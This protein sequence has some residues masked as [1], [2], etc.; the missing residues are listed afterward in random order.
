M[1]KLFFTILAYFLLATAF[2]QTKVYLVPTLHGMHKTNTQY[3]YDS[4]KAVVARIHPDVIAVEIRPEDIQQ[5]SSYLKNNYPYEMWM[6]PHWFA[7]ATI[8]GFDWLGADIENKSIPQRYWQDQSRPKYLQRR[9]QLDSVYTA[10][11][12]SCQ[13]YTD[14]RMAILNNQSLN[15]ILASNDALLVKEYYNC[16]ELQ[17]RNSDYE[18]LAA[19]YTMRN[20]KMMTN[21]DVLLQKHNGKT[22]VV[23]TGDDHYPYLLEHFKKAKVTIGRL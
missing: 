1:R 15:S 4:V 12:K 14:A 2:S 9:L 13:L 19:F 20:A 3:N 17:L 8:E 6:M 11:T 18:E 7:T 22:I 16:L 21:L 23:L 5:D 10:R